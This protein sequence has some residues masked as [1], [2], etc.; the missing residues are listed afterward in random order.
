MIESSWFCSILTTVHN[1]H[2]FKHSTDVD[3]LHEE[4]PRARPCVASQAL[5]VARRHGQAYGEK[6]NVHQQRRHQAQL[7]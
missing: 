5:A 1:G 7:S 4:F 2:I 3:F 6:G